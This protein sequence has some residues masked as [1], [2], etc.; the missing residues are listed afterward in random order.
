MDDK[1]QHRLAYKAQHQRD[2]RARRRDDG[3]P[4]RRDVAEALLAAVL[5]RKP[6]GAFVAVPGLV[7]QG[8]DA[9]EARCVIAQIVAAANVDTVTRQ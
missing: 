2:A 4:E 6:E 1:R 7:E 9:D 5:G 3:R 8:F